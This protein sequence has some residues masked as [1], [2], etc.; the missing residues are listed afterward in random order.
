MTIEPTHGAED[1]E[2]LQHE[3]EVLEQQNEAL[4]SQVE[5]SKGP[6]KSRGRTIS[7]WILLVLACLLAVLSVVV[8]YARNELLNTNTFVAT[9]GPLAKDPAVQAAVATKVSESLVAK[10]DIQ[11]RIK[12]ALPARA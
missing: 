7:S 11:Q 12:E 5:A 6:K 3:V 9:V 1:A 2:A 4:R 8:V 10:T